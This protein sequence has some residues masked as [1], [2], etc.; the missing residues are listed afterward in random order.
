M[1]S[2]KIRRLSHALG[3]EISGID[4][5]GPLDKSTFGDIYAEFLKYGILLFR[6]QALTRE[7][8]IAFG[9]NFGELEVTPAY[10]IANMDAAYPELVLVT[11][12]PKP[13]SAPPDRRSQGE[14]WHSDRSFS[15]IPAQASLLRAVSLPAV[16]G[17]TLFS[18]A[19]LAYDTL[20]DGM[21]KLLDGLHGAHIQEGSRT[22]DH[23]SPERLAETRRQTR[24]A[25]P[26]VRVHP[27]TGRKS[28][29]LAYRVKK[30]VGMTVEESAPLL[31]LL[32]EHATRPQFVYRHVWQKDDLMIWDN[33]CTLHN[34]VNDYDR[35]E[36]RHLERVTVRGT[37][38]GYPYDE[39]Q[40]V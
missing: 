35:S 24:T 32:L 17:D 10:R 23:S 6:G 33:R 31:Q 27:D 2:M 21:K 14:G 7:Q 37:P 8:H 11:N 1:A 3:A 4:I 36:L 16:G 12:K 9:R 25:H 5:R 28:L 13:S 15:A 20:S 29:Y 30:I 26:L 19:C 38:S 39:T 40:D 34:A 18:N 22:L